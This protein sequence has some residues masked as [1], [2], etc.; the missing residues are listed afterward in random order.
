[1][2]EALRTCGSGVQRAGQVWRMRVGSVCSLDRAVLGDCHRIGCRVGHCCIGRVVKQTTQSVGSNTYQHANKHSRFK[3]VHLKRLN[4]FSPYP[5][6][7]LKS[8]RKYLFICIYL[9][10]STKPKIICFA[11]F[12]NIKETDYLQ[13][14]TFTRHSQNIFRCV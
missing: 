13:L 9:K 14:N 1:M 11:F 12:H 2:L 10:D 3:I 6:S 7:F 5:C 4:I 8:I